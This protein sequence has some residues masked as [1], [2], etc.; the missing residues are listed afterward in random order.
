MRKCVDEFLEVARVN[1]RPMR[2]A[3]IRKIVL[4]AM[5]KYPGCEKL[6]AVRIVGH[7]DAWSIAPC[8]S[9]ARFSEQ[10]Q[11]A[12]SAVVLELSDKYSCSD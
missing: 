11:R 8:D 5:R 6:A 10:V 4:D 7:L 2:R 1:K 12:A 9:A 3:E